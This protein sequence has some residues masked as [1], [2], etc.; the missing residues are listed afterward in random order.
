MTNKFGRGVVTSGPGIRVQRAPRRSD[1]RSRRR[2]CRLTERRAFDGWPV[3]VVRG[4]RR[5]RVAV[6]GAPP[7]GASIDAA[8]AP[9][10]AEVRSRSS[11]HVGDTQIRAHLDEE[12]RIP[13]A[14]R[15]RPARLGFETLS[16]RACPG[17]V[18]IR[19]ELWG[20]GKSRAVPRRRW[21]RITTIAPMQCVELFRAVGPGC[22][23]DVAA[24]ARRNVRRRPTASRGRCTAAGAAA[25]HGAR[26]A[27][28]ATR[29]AGMPAVR[30]ALP[31]RPP[32]C[33][34]TTTLP[35]G[36]SPEPPP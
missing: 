24:V 11:T 25:G 16:T 7:D 19:Q 22:P 12:L 14:L 30:G 8:G 18:K 21:A 5:L 17:C 29:R 33:A 23:A 1:R 20:A 32:A 4:E 34:T 36:G 26:S 15:L 35:P 13:G 10:G 27:A 6:P 3:C 2:G 31:R 9:R 28:V